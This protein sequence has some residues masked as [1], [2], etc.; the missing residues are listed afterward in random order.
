MA[1]SVP[2]IILPIMALFLMNWRELLAARGAAVSRHDAEFSFV[3]H[4]GAIGYETLETRNI[5]RFQQRDFFKCA[6][7]TK[8]YKLVNSSVLAGEYEDDNAKSYYPYNKYTV[9]EDIWK[10]EL[11]EVTSRDKALA[12]DG[13]YKCNHCNANPC[14]CLSPEGVAELKGKEADN[15]YMKKVFRN[16]N[17]A[18]YK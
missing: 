1:A 10:Y 6:E 3:C 5:N 2:A 17:R 15:D 4:K 18:V 14:K 11:Q 7:G 16:Y 13:F 9:E 12:K 8:L